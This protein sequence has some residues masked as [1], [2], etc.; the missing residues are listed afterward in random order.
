MPQSLSHR[1]I[2]KHETVLTAT[3]ESIFAEDSDGIHHEQADIKQP[4]E[5]EHHDNARVDWRFEARPRIGPG[6]KVC[7]KC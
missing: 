3:E 1:P 2:S 7:V 6:D 4:S 5:E